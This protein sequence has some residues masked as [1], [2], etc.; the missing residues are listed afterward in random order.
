MAEAVMA[1]A[2][3]LWELHAG[4]LERARALGIRLEDEKEQT[5]AG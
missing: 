4:A 5:A 1:E 3:A 2:E